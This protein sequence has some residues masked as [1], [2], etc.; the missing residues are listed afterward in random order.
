MRQKTDPEQLGTIE[1]G[2]T[3]PT[4]IFMKRAGIGK[5]ALM[6][7]RRKGL[8]VI[9]MGNRTFVRGRDFSAFLAGMTADQES[10]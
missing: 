7:L 1:D 3:Y 4:P 10:V 6:M 5:H 9:R 2:T 8:K